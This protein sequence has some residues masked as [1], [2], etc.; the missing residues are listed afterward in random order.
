M[1]KWLFHNIDYF[2]CPVQITFND[3]EKYSTILGK[4]LSIIIYCVTL[5]LIVSSWSSLFNRQNPKTSTTITYKKI[6]PLMNLTELNSIYIA[7]FQTSDFL[8]FNDPSYLSFETNLFEVKRFENG[9][10]SFSYVPLKTK[11][12]SDYREI[13][14]AKGFEKDYDGN[15]LDQGVCIDLKARDIVL[16]GNFASN[17]FSNFVYNLKKCVNSTDSNIICKPQEDI[18]KKIKGGFFQFFYFDNFVDLNN[19]SKVF[20]EYLIHYYIVLDPKSSKFVDAYFKYVNVSSDIGLI[21]EEKKYLS[22]VSYDYNKEQIDTSSTDNLVI[23]F[24][25]NSSNNYVSYTRIYT[26]FQEFAATIG[27]LLKIMT[28]LGTLITST[29]T[30]YE[31]REK[32]FNSIFDFRTKKS[33]LRDNNHLKSQAP[34]K[35]TVHYSPNLKYKDFFNEASPNSEK[36]DLKQHKLL[37]RL[38]KNKFNSNKKEK[39]EIKL[40]TCHLL[41]MIVC[42]CQKNEQLKWKLVKIASKKLTKYLDYLKISS[43]LQDMD[44]VKKV[45]FNQHQ[46][47]ILGISSKP[48]IMADSNNNFSSISKLDDEE[49]YLALFYNYCAVRENINDPINER[50][51]NCMDEK[52]KR[53]FD[54]IMSNKL[55]GNL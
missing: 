8:P 53:K 34:L 37:L 29:F 31:M 24:Y 47:K 48:N 43:T 3:R 52:F 13:F 46:R 6:S 18:D 39:S 11:N 28:F 17:Y 30:Q 4:I 12:C 27:G 51:L 26:K 2:S 36:R 40:G 49:K 45:L 41:K 16:G 50:L 14:K 33:V 1:I 15:Y 54:D 20:T 38:V 44:R 7:L 32:M 10:A 9:S 5:A 21:F 35:E 25:V 23:K 19:Y 22:A 42:C 55:T